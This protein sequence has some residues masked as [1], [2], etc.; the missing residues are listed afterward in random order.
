M[1]ASEHRSVLVFS[2]T[3]LIA[4]AQMSSPTLSSKYSPVCCRGHF[5]HALPPRGLLLLLLAIR[6]PAVAPVKRVAVTA[7]GDAAVTGDS[8]APSTQ[9]AA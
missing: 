1:S 7:T 3:F 9:F 5:T 6:F 4:A 8:A 2:L